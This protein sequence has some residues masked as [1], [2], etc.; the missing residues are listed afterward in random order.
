MLDPGT[1]TGAQVKVHLGIHAC[2]G[3]EGFGW[4]G[5]GRY[6]RELTAALL[7]RHPELIGGIHCDAERQV[8][9]TMADFCGHGLVQQH[10]QRGSVT[11]YRDPAVYH[12]MSPLWPVTPADRV[13]PRGFRG[14]GHKLIVTLHDLI[15]LRYPS[16]YLYDPAYDHWFRS[17][18]RLIEEA[19]WVIAVSEATRQD[20]FRFL[21]LKE[22]KVRVVYEGVGEQFRPADKPMTELRGELRSRIPGLMDRY[23]IF[24][25]GTAQHRKNIPG[26]IEGFAAIP[27][28]FRAGT[29]LVITGFFEP[30]QRRG[31]E[32]L[33]ASCGVGGRVLLPGF[34]DD[35]LLLRLYQ[36]CS[37]C[38]FPSLHEGFGLP[39]LEAMRS[40]A[41]VATSD[42][43][44]LK[45]LVE[46]PEAR[47]DPERPSD[48]AR[49]ITQLLSNG[50]LLGRVKEY[51]QRRA[52][53]F[54]WDRAAGETADIYNEVL[55]S[56]ASPFRQTATSSAPSEDTAPE[57]KTRISANAN[58]A[59]SAPRVYLSLRGLQGPA[60]TRHRGWVRYVYDHA[61]RLIQ[62]FPEFIAGLHIGAE[63]PLPK[64]L[65]DFSGY[66]LLRTS[67]RGQGSMR[68]SER[69]QIFHIMSVIFP[70][71]SVPVSEAFP[72]EFSRAPTKL[73]VT[74]HDLIPLRFD[75]EFPPDPRYRAD[76]GAS[77]RL[78]QQ[79]D[80]VMTNSRAT[81]NDAVGFLEVDQGRVRVIYGG[82]SDAFE[83][84]SRPR[85][86]LL[87]R[88]LQLIPAITGPYVLSMLYGMGSRK[89]MEGL[90]DAF[91][92]IQQQAPGYQLVLVGHEAG[93]EN[94]HRL[95]ERAKRAGIANRLVFTGVVSDH[96]LRLLYQACEVFIYPSLY[97]GLGLPVIE[98][99][100]CGA[101]AIISDRPAMNELVEPNDA[102]FNPEDADDIARV[103]VTAL[104]NSG[105]RQ[106]L[107]E[108]GLHR[109]QRFTWRRVAEDTADCYRDMIQSSKNYAPTGHRPRYF[110]FCAPPPSSDDPSSNYVWNVL[111]AA[112]AQYPLKIDIV[113]DNENEFA[114]FAKPPSVAF[115]S[116]RQFL[117]SAQRG[118]YDAI[119]YCM[120][121][122]VR[123]E[124]SY[125]LLKQQRGIV[126]LQDVR[127]TTFYRDRYA[128]VG[129]D[130]RRLPDE[131]RHWARRYPEHETDLLLWDIHKQHEYGVFL[132]GE[133]INHSD[134]VLVNSRFAADLALLEG[135]E[136]CEVAILPLA[137][138]HEA[139]AVKDAPHSRSMRTSDRR[140]IVSLGPITPLSCPETVIDAFSILVTRLDSP[141]LIF[142]GPYEGD[143]RKRL[144]QRTSQLGLHE[145]M[146][147][148][149]GIAD[150]QMLAAADCA[151]QLDFPS[152]GA[153][154]L[155]ATRSLALGIPT[156]IS[157]HGPLRDL[158]ADAAKR[159]PVEAEPRR[160]AQ[161]IEEILSDS[162]NSRKL[163]EVGQRY[164]REA[165]FE[166]V[167]NQLWLEIFNCR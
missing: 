145:R 1:R 36:G 50:T 66:G 130:L 96:Q 97:E 4:H 99:M 133:V 124:S 20:A 58:R 146:Q 144:E 39:V 84:A 55:E 21:K 119:V 152:S 43:S 40:G 11:Q 163:G 83:P 160:L 67:H 54:T 156:I 14:R 151:V 8:P 70:E 110:A 29:Q 149:D 82:V 158:P 60:W 57:P 126:W 100:A 113:A 74:L 59:S 115:V 87:R 47:F 28:D 91:G 17:R 78:V 93:E 7:R 164:A 111:T 9:R 159:L 162:G 63:A 30:A 129:H 48:I 35:D 154:P 72:P 42:G 117:W 45:E 166:K 26:A 136:R 25:A 104:T 18:L 34:V 153:L 92:R 88:L 106:G 120:G 6:T 143:L 95:D 114:L 41:P 139:S 49:V 76:Y 51:G 108:Y 94:M 65:A 128:D 80:L 167:A 122:D 105:Y 32:D 86:A 142:N 15:P 81:A 37:L 77:L 68:P 10:N 75:Y 46:M 101:P 71:G 98:A 69:P 53:E 24:A 12:L 118:H 31:F 22:D 150:S 79:A 2:Q 132:A 89:N 157:D 62:D 85:E 147:F 102:R 13:L 73:A 116:K 90:I 134:R 140:L 112:C 155:A 27:A 131:L 137:I 148:V 121:N 109:A 165:S 16:H 107:R 19:D 123:Y 125:T 138:P 5:L 52:N 135:D 103:M 64:R 127:L 56:I 38:I 23:I 141:K 33:A 161:T 61:A 44:S 3:P